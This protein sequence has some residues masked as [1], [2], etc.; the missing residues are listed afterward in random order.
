[1]NLPDVLFD[2]M[3]R[4]PPESIRILN[5]GELDAFGLS[6]DDPVAQ[7]LDDAE[8]AR[9]FGISKEENRQPTPSVRFHDSSLR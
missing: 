2:A 5:A 4:I 8:E 7:E 6:Q 1:M 9:E 3:V